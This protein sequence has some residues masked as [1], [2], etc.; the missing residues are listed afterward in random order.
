MQLL[1]HRARQD[2]HHHTLKGQCQEKSFQ[3]EV[4]STV[5]TKG[6]SDQNFIF[7]RCLFNLLRIFKDGAHRSKTEYM[8]GHGSGVNVSL[9]HWVVRKFATHSFLKHPGLSSGDHVR[10][11]PV[12]LL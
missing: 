5:G 2:A 7:V 8:L 10:N 4:G 3:T 9:R 6:V 1:A 12:V 11:H